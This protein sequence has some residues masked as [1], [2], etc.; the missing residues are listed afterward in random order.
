MRSGDDAGMAIPDDQL[1]VA[2]GW[3]EIKVL[4]GP[5][6]VLTSRGYAPVLV[7]QHVLTGLFYRLYIGAKTL[8]EPLE[9][10]R[11]ENGG[12][13]GLRLRIRK[14]SMDPMSKYQVEELSG[15]GR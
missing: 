4:G 15:S 5:D 11:Q 2:T 12:F 7:V 10:M 8:A 3:V 9:K 6:V 1:R 13:V 14:E